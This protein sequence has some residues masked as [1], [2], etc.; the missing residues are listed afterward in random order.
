ME[1]VNLIVYLCGCACVRACVAKR[2]IKGEKVR[3]NNKYKMLTKFFYFYFFQE[4]KHKIFLKHM[5]EILFYYIRRKILSF[6][7]KSL[8]YKFLKF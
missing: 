6:Y 1:S 7:I 2:E 3:V 4:F 8:K 5:F